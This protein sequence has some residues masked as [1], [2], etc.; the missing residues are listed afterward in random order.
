M[1]LKNNKHLIQFMLEEK[2]I[3]K[4]M[5]HRISQYFS[6]MYRCFKRVT[7]VGSGNYIYFW[8]YAEL[9]DENVTAPTTSDYSLNPQVSYLGTKSRVEFKG[10]CLKQDK[11]T[12][13]H[14]KIVNIF[15]FHERSKT[16]NVSIFPTLENCF[17]GA[18][19]LTRN[20]DID[21]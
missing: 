11:I 8:R 12:F 19:S 20:A 5:I 4:K 6:P 2:V 9:S 1:N 10:R 3:L 16:F 7:G 14:R 13:D 18:V 21:K 17:F 15:I